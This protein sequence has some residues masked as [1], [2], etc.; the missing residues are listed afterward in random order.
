[1]TLLK[2]KPKGIPK[3]NSNDVYLVLDQQ[4]DHRVLNDSPYDYFKAYFWIGSRAKNHQ[5]HVEK[6]ILLL[7]QVVEAHPPGRAKLRV[8]IE[9]Q[10]SESFEFFTLFNRMESIPGPSDKKTHIFCAV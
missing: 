5:S 10:Y 9:F 1:M 3:F 8:W 6:A 7:D 4:H 2:N